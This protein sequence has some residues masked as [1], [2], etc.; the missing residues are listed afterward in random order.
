MDTVNT[1]KNYDHLLQ[2]YIT[3]QNKSEFYKRQASRLQQDNE[4]LKEILDPEFS[5]FDIH[6]QGLISPFDWTE[7]DINKHVTSI[8]GCDKDFPT[9][10]N[11]LVKLWIPPEEN[12]YG[13][14]LTEHSRTKEMLTSVT[15]QVLRMGK[16]AF[17][18]RARF[19]TGPLITYGQWGLFREHTRQV[20]QRNGHRI[21]YIHDDRFVA[22]IEDPSTLK[23]A[24]ELQFEHTDN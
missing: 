13:V 21:A 2:S 23:T 9:G 18:D 10:Y 8:I 3:E 5:E 19:P 6:E 14:L 22:V 11:V 4:R 1:D 15:G 12:E 16:S 17:R 7:E 20:V 24:F